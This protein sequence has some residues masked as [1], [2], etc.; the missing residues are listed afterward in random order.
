MKFILLVIFSCLLFSCQYL[1]PKQ[2]KEAKLIAKVGEKVL[3]QSNLS[4][5]TPANLSEEDSTKFAE[6][7]VT[8]WVK[9][10]LMIRRAEEVIDFDQ[11]RIQN[12]VLDYQYAL[13]VHELEEKYIDT[14]LNEEVSEREVLTYYESKSENFI[15][16]QNL[17][18][19]IYFKI[20]ESAPQK[21]KLRKAIKNYPSDSLA[22]WQYVN[23]H[24]VNA[25]TED[26]VWVAFDEVL[27]ETPMRDISDKAAF[28]QKNS[29]VEVSDE[30]F[31]YFLRII[32][33][34]VVGEVAP[35]EFIRESVK[36]IIINKRKIDL[37][38]ELEKKIY[39]EALQTDAFEIYNH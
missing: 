9:K 3:L 6:K 24:A 13:M 26:S 15:L 34:K 33:F 4:D 38:R 8:D 10:Q 19:C 32:D 5:L 23:K 31:V 18:K 12:K 20:S 7:F 16:R 2:E 36:D 1:Q 22:L 37:K 21:R 35:L 27:L 28:L 25:F 30:D 11:A 39:D 29:Y 14:H 17:T